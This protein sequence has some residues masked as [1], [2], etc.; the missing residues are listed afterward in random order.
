MGGNQRLK[1]LQQTPFS[2]HPPS[3][4]T[5]MF[6]VMREAKAAWVPQA[7]RPPGT[8]GVAELAPPRPPRPPRPPGAA[9][10]ARAPL[11]TSSTSLPGHQ[12]HGIN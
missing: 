8:A 10:V 2:A 9:G 1:Q 5:T 4:I 7:P 3:T 12:K 11:T 6:P